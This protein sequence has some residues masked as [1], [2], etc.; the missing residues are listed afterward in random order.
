MIH[1][2]ALLQNL[3]PALRDLAFE[4]EEAAVAGADLAGIGY[5]ALAAEIEEAVGRVGEVAAQLG[6]RRGRVGAFKRPEVLGSLCQPGSSAAAGAGHALVD[7]VGEGEVCAGSRH[8]RGHNTAHEVERAARLAAELEGHGALSRVEVLEEQHTFLEGAPGGEGVAKAPG[9]PGLHREHGRVVVYAGAVHV[10]LGVAA[11][12]I[13]HHEH[14]AAA[15][16]FR[17]VVLHHAGAAYV[18][19]AFIG[20]GPD[21]Q[22]AVLLGGGAADGPYVLGL[23]G[24]G[25]VDIVVI[26][27]HVAFGAGGESA[28]EVAP[29]SV[30][31][32]VVTPLAAHRQAGLDFEVSNCHIGHYAAVSQSAELEV[33]ALLGGLDGIGID[34][35]G[36]QIVGER[37]EGAATQEQRLVDGDLE[38]RALAALRYGH[39]G[40][41]EGYKARRCGHERLLLAL[42]VTLY[43]GVVYLQGAFQTDVLDEIV[44]LEVQYDGLLELRHIALLIRLHLGAVHHPADALL[45]DGKGGADKAH[46]HHLLGFGDIEVGGLHAHGKHIIRALA[47][48][49]RELAGVPA[50]GH[51]LYD[52]FL[53]EFQIAPAQ[54][55]PGSGNELVGSLV[56]AVVFVQGGQD[57]GV[58]EAH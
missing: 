2:V 22:A 44:H 47:D 31:G 25:K 45:G 15:V 30:G 58:L 21:G 9:G 1:H 19:C 43:Q 29:G 32:G 46:E 37:L 8:G 53:P 12:H 7:V 57:G 42:V 50:D 35:H 51:V 36:H 38:G 52:L 20:H 13:R 16:D 23:V 33:L 24:L 54:A 14:V 26:H 39:A 4:D 17:V 27:S 55:E 28:D 40:G 3:A 56:F 11:V 5:V 41:L 6:Q 18:E 34:G 48:E 49:F 10:E